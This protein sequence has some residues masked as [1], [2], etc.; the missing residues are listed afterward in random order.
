MKFDI[1]RL[2]NVGECCFF[3][4]PLSHPIVFYSKEDYF[5]DF[6]LFFPL[7]K[8]LMLAKLCLQNGRRP[9]LQ[10]LRPN[11]SRYLS[12]DELASFDLSVPS[13]CMTVPIIYL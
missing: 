1:L 11:S 9:V 10:L 5:H 13:L 7:L 8:H 12:P 6:L 4:F 3:L 2:D